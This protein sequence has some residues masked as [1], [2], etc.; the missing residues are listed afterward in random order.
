M[1]RSN[2]T[3]EQTGADLQAADLQALASA[4]LSLP[5]PVAAEALQAEEVASECEPDDS[6]PCADC[7]DTIDSGDERTSNSGDHYCETCYNDAYNSCDMCGAETPSDESHSVDYRSYSTVCGDCH[8]N[9]FFDCADCNESTHNNDRCGSNT[10][11]DAVCDGCSESYCTCDSCNE[12]I[13]SDDSY[14]NER[15][16]CTE[17]RDC[18]HTGGTD[19]IAGMRFDLQAALRNTSEIRSARTF[20]VELETSECDGCSDLDGVTYFS[21]KDDGSIDGYEFVSTVLAGDAGL[22]AIRDFCERAQDAGFKT[23]GQCGFHAHFGA[24]DLQAEQ[25][26]AVAIAYRA[27][28]EVWSAFVPR[29]RATNTYCGP[30]RWSVADVQC[31]PDVFDWAENL[32]RYQW[33]NLSAYGAHQTIEIRI[34]SPTLA[35]D[36]VAN[37]VIAHCRFIDYAATLSPAEAIALFDGKSVAE[38]FA[39]IARIWSDE[40]LTAY[41]LERA[42][43]FGRDLQA[44]TSPIPATGTD[45][46]ALRNPPRELTQEEIAAGIQSGAFSHDVNSCGCSSC[47]RS[48]QSYSRA[49]PPL[50]VASDPAVIVRQASEA[51]A[52]LQ[53]CGDNVAYD[54]AR[55]F[56][57]IVGIELERYTSRVAQRANEYTGRYGRGAGYG[58]TAAIAEASEALANVAGYG[59]DVP[60]VIAAECASLVSTLQAFGIHPLTA[61]QRAEAIRAAA[62]L[63]TA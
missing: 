41:Y 52:T 48:M 61:N 24:G 57:G 19:H 12:T 45:A 37:W 26:R 25:Y 31:E 49:L 6:L 16:G 17:C 46:S 35:A 58:L 43:K 34:H 55:H 20:G 21:S 54:A 1:P 29:D 10:S 42:K 36:K 38:N 62:A 9:N 23:N 28:Q 32:D 3:N 15:R 11:G 50:E 14:Y 8:D 60:R 47:R 33:V 13:H 30:A 5:S 44:E 39:T 22:R 53:A 4:D 40:P 56:R 7:G 27:T 59:A 51:L 2:R 63:A 18:Y